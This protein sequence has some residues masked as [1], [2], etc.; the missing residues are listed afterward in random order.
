MKKYLI[1]VFVIISATANA[2]VTRSYVTR[3]SASLIYQIHKDT[4]ITIPN[5]DSGYIN[6]YGAYENIYSRIRY[7]DSLTQTLTDGATIT[8]NATLGKSARVTL[9]GNRTLSITNMY[10]GEFLSL[11]VIQ[12][13]TGGRTL[14]L[15]PCKVID[16]GA[17]AVPL[18]GA[19]GSRDILTFWKINDIIFCN[20]G[21]N[22]N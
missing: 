5:Q 14:T 3:D 6:G 11:V 4:I 12:D 10:N 1:L 2:Q 19:G 22:Y 13:A 15:P 17:G 7:A 9:G 20:Y 8:F 16:G 18:S 21:K